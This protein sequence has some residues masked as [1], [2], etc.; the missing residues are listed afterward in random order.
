MARITDAEKRQV[1]LDLN[2]K[3]RLEAIFR[4]EIRKLF[5]RVAKTYRVGVVKTGRSI[6]AEDF[7]ND[8]NHLIFK[9]HQRT[10]RAFRKQQK[11]ED[12]DNDDEELLLLALLLWAERNSAESAE[13]ITATNQKNMNNALTQ[14]RRI[15][16]EQELEPSNRTLAATA[17]ALIMR[18]FNGRVEAIT[19][20]E[21]QAAG[22][23]TKLTVAEIGAGIEPSVLSGIVS[24]PGMTA[25]KKWVTEG[26]ER[27]RVK[28]FNHRAAEGQVKKINEPFVVGGQLLMFPGDKS[29]GAT[30]K[31]TIKCRCWAVYST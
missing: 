29:L 13:E 3:L 10:Q 4:P 18:K 5:I 25:T 19:S 14:A 9:H 30:I 21:T 8:W 11:Q 1:A 17:G 20:F 31:N 26:D 7:K 23:S 15:V 28:P 12:N 22:G 27:V 16:T 6:D 24:T 2:N